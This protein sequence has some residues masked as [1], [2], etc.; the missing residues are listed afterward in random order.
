MFGIILGANCVE[1]IVYNLT[2]NTINR[3]G[4]APVTPQWPHA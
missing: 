4:T 1:I 3:G 2:N